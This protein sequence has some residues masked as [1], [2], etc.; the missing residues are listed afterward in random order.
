MAQPNQPPVGPIE[1]WV[2]RQIREAMDRGEFDNL[3]GEGKPLPGIDDPPDPLW[4][5]KRKMKREGL[6]VVP[7]S[8]ALRK[9]AED[10][11]DLAE[12]AGTEEEVRRII[13]K[14]NVK[15]EAAIRTPPM[16]PP[17]NLMPYKVERIVRRWR[18]THK[19]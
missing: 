8:L 6:S 3:P 13:E 15:I 9:E 14:I 17:L 10:A 1:N 4:W 18:E 19:A 12:R 11:L 2:E 7:P 16:G 5:I